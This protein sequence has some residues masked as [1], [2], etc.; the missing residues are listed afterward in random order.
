MRNELHIS[1]AT[2]TATVRAGFIGTLLRPAVTCIATAGLA[3]AGCDETKS[4]RPEA[5]APP[6]QNG[7]QLTIREAAA[8]DQSREVRWTPDALDGRAAEPGAATGSVLS[9]APDREGWAIVL[10]TSTQPDHRRIVSEWLAGFRQATSLTQGWVESDERGSIVRFGS[11]PSVESKEAQADLATLKNFVLNDRLP[12]A[13]AYLAKYGGSDAAGR[14][15][16]YN[17]TQARKFYPREDTVYSLQIGVY[18][19]EQATTAEEARRLAE[20]AVVQLRSQGEMAFYYHGPNRSMVCVGVFPSTAADAATGMY[21]P[22]VRALQQRFPYNTF[23]GRSL[24]QEILTTSGKKR[25]ELQ[26]SFLV[27]VPAQ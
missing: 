8:G 18:E 7:E 19:A 9:G 3:I 16:E 26:P 17:L 2:A 21:S 20:E 13:R 1:S 24:K 6:A 14:V 4:T 25:E 23:N 12:F 22:E 27:Q 5:G 10:Y 15:R 11:Y